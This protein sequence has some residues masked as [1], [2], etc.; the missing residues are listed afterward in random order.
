MR[1]KGKLGNWASV[2]S[3]VKE[4]EKGLGFKGEE[5]NSE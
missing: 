2:P 5:D 1:L 3:C 4:G